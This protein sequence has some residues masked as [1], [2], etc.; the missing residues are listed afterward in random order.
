[1]N[2]NQQSDAMS[3]YY[4]IVMWDSEGFCWAD[5]IR[6]VQRAETITDLALLHGNAADSMRAVE[7]GKCRE[8]TEEEKL[9]LWQETARMAETKTSRIA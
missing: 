9:E 2:S 7:N 8:L 4:E 1:M 6:P 3:I 5:P